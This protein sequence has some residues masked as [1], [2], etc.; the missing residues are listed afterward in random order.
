MPLAPSKVRHMHPAFGVLALA[1][2]SIDVVRRT[3]SGRAVPPAS[4]AHEVV[5][6]PA[7]TVEIG[8]CGR[9]LGGHVGW[10]LTLEHVQLGDQLCSASAGVLGQDL[11]GGIDADAHGDAGD[12]FL[13]AVNRPV[14]ADVLDGLADVVGDGVDD[15]GPRARD[16]AT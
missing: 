1:T 12:P 13:V 5:T 7:K 4:A 10:C 6:G 14:M 16:M 3:A 8:T 2:R 15:V 11:A 9:E